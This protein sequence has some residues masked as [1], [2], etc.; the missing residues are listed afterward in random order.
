MSHPFKFPKLKSRVRILDI[1]AIAFAVAAVVGV[2]V[3]AYA[4]G[5]TASEVVVQ[6]DGKDYLYP[7]DRNTTFSVTGPIGRTVIEIDDHRVRVVSSPCKDKI[8]ILAGWLSHNGQWTACL[9][10][11]VFV[12]VAG[13][14]SDTVDAQTF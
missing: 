14:P 9:P 13:S 5:T 6:A 11:K 10:N 7:L 2:S 3:Y 12:R 4:G 1:V 8:C